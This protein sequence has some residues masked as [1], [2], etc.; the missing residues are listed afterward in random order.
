MQLDCK[1]YGDDKMIKRVIVNEIKD[2]IKHYPIIL[3][4]GPRQIGKSTLLYNWIMGS[5][6]DYVSLDDKLEL[7]MA[8]SDPKTFFTVHKA[9]LIID[10]AQ[11]APEL[12]P[13]IE[14]IVNKSRLEKGNKESNGMYI[15]SGSQ[16]KQLLD[17]AKESLSGRVAILD[18][19]NLSLNEIINRESRI[20]NT[21]INTA[22]T[23]TNPVISENV[24]FNYIVRGFFPIL[25][26]DL[27]M[28]TS[29]FYSSYLTTY[30]EKDLKDLITVNDEIKFIN[31][32]KI[33]ASNTGEE[34]V[35]DNYAKQ[36]GVATNTIKSWISVLVKTAIIYLVEPYNE[37]SIVKRVV[38][39]PK[40]YFFDTGLVAYLTRYSSPE[41]LQNG[42]INGAILENYIVCEI[43]KTYRNSAK[44]CLIHYYRDKESNEIDIVLESDGVLHPVEIKKSSNPGTE[45]TGPF[46]IL[47]KASVPRGTGAIL[48]LKNELSAIDRQNLIIPAWMI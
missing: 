40:M 48:C 35:Y 36:V 39:R 13:E 24:I 19:M 28:K 26:D 27:E 31:F 47:D 2:A 10:E 46:D 14:A 16:R 11:K 8:K 37:S 17:E 12:F 25:Y 29:L 6:Y 15:L 23:R 33:L 34:L 44:D 20:F 45:L 21:D 18:M 1:K 5:T 7:S 9:P 4:T 38:K 41:I 43:I 3:L 30:L 42:A 32:L 22:S